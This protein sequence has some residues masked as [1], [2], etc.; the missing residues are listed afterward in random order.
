MS[1]RILAIGG[2]R[3]RKL[4]QQ[5]GDEFAV[6]LSD[7]SPIALTQFNGSNFEAVILERELDNDSRTVLQGQLQNQNPRLAVVTNPQAVA[8][9]L[10]ESVKAAIYDM[11]GQPPLLG[12]ATLDGRQ[13]L[14]TAAE[15]CP[16]QVTACHIGPFGAP[17][18]NTI[19]SGQAEAGDNAVSV[20]LSATGLFGSTYIILTANNA[21][22]QIIKL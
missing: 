17:H 20:P 9:V 8:P 21:E 3:L 7:S 15:T 4:T 5:L 22:K 14:F 1:I 16:L 6:V 13:L 2:E 12:E 10:G 11:T 18:F 19:Y